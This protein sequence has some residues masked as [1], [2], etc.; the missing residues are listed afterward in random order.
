MK[1]GRGVSPVKSGTSKF[2]A[3]KLEN[4][5]QIGGIRTGTLDGQAAGGAQG[6]RV[7]LFDTGSGLRFTVAL[8]RGGDI[9]DTHFNQY[10]LAYLTPNGILPPSHAYH[11]ELEWLRAWP[12][13]LMTTCG[14]ESIGEPRELIGGRSSLHGRYSNT[15]A[16]VGSVV[17]PDLRAGRLDMSLHLFVRDSRTFG[18]NFEI[19][20]EIRCR[21]G[22]PDIWVTDEVTNTGDTPASHH[23]LYHCNFGYPLLDAGSRF[24]YKGRAERWLLPV[25]P[26]ESPLRP[27]STRE[28]NRMKKAAGPLAEYSGSAE[29]GLLVEVEP[30]SGGLCRIGLINS[31]IKLGLAIDYPSQALPRMG[32]WQ[33]YGPRGCYVSAFE[34]FYGSLIGPATDSFPNADPRLKPGASRRY[35]IHFRVCST[36]DELKDLADQDG[37]VFP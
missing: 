1:K 7:A 29:R 25:P 6:V 32:N 34:P 13:G 37:P 16:T 4:V 9:V 19:H 21:L 23:W 31:R 12:A 17:N 10:G 27:C 33:H 5:Y 14:P 28:M 18:P 24:I 36:A 22:E 30:D 15:P 3:D 20:R 11:S 2:D 35:A 26:G 8:D